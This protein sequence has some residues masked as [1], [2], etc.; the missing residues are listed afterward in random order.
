M[1]ITAVHYASICSYAFTY[2]YAQNYAS[3]IRQDLTGS[4]TEGEG[5]KARLA[6]ALVLFSFFTIE[7]SASVA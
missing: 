3:I 1:L 4:R 2:Y 5:D 7:K 6:A